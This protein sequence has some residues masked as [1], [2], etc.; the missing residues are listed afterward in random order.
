MHFFIVQNQRFCDFFPRENHGLFQRAGCGFHAFG[1]FIYM[2]ECTERR[3]IACR[4]LGTHWKHFLTHW[5][6]LGAWNSPYRSVAKKVTDWTI[7]KNML[8]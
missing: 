1:L 4:H 3:E 2:P 7:K 6:S 5:R 8:I